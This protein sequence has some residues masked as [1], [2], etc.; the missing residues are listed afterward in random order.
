MPSSGKRRIM[1]IFNKIVFPPIAEGVTEAK[2]KKITYA[3]TTKL[4]DIRTQ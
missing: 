3:M 2:G 1:E 4:K